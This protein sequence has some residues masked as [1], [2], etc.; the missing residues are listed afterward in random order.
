MH[1]PLP[2]DDFEAMVTICSVLHGR[3]REAM[4]ESDSIEILNVA[5]AADK[6]A[7]TAPLSWAARD[8]LKCEGIKDTGELWRLT[9]AAYL[10]DDQEG[11]A[12]ATRGL[13][14][15]HNGSE[16]LLNVH[17]EFPG[18]TDS[19]SLLIRSRS[20]STSGSFGRS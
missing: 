15:H 5:V 2:E 19:V 17:A 18:M 13:I 12:D 16:F 20:Y 4:A 8:W 6:W 1:L 10:L 9:L 3:S 11:F 7:C 14:F